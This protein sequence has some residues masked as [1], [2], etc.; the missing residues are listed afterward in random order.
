M[1]ALCLVINIQESEEDGPMYTGY[2]K[3]RNLGS[4]IKQGRKSLSLL[5]P[6]LQSSANLSDGSQYL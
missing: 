3:T 5:L 4:K 1:T 6:R 2:K